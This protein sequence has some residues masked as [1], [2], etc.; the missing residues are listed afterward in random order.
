MTFIIG[1]ICS[2]ILAALIVIWIIY[3]MFFKEKP[4]SEAYQFSISDLRRKNYEIA[5]EQE[6]TNEKVKEVTAGIFILPSK[7]KHDNIES[8]IDKRPDYPEGTI[9]NIQPRMDNLIEIFDDS[10]LEADKRCGLEAETYQSD[11]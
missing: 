2:L 10:T 6:V 1:F 11:V 7:K 8:Y 3:C 5:Q 9:G 4:K